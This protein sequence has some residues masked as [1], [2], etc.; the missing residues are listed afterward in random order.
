MPKRA[1]IALVVVFVLTRAL[2]G[3]LAYNP[4]VY[5]GETQ[6]AGD[7]AIYHYY[8]N[9]ILDGGLAP[10]GDI[11]I[12]YPPGSLVLITIPYALSSDAD[13]YRM[14]FIIEMILIDA[15]GAVA[16]LILGRRW[17]QR[18]GV[19]AWVFLIPFLGPIAH[20][21]LDLVPAVLT[22]WAFE[23][24]SARRWLESGAALGVGTAIKLYPIALLP[25]LFLVSWRRRQLLIGAALPLIAVALPYLGNLKEVFDAVIGYQT[26]RGLQV[27]STWG[28]ALLFASN[29]G[30]DVTTV[31]NFGAFHVA[32][33]ASRFLDTVSTIASGGIAIATYWLSNRHIERG[34]VRTA[35]LL[36]FSLITLLLVVAA[37]W[38]PQ[39]LIWLIALAAV[40]LCARGASLRHV[41]Y[42]LAGAGVASQ[43]AY[44]FFYIDLLDGNVFITSLLLVRNVAV[45]VAGV[46]V[47]LVALPHVRGGTLQSEQ[48]AP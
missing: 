17:R 41:A 6:V 1:A 10:Y 11:D 35:S 28:V 24:A 14:L 30:Y 45:A 18:W 15:L 19:W 2:S 8:A 20:V 4:D 7:V 3:W 12:E 27:E 43:I 40:A 21:R 42:V 13:T 16:L 33:S 32:S 22:I 25:I 23:R 26:G 9:Q 37:V 5:K 38:S 36:S 46:A 29:L 39:F 44:P 47:L 34:D 48:A 31:Y